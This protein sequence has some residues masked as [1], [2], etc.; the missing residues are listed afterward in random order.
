MQQLLKRQI[1]FWGAV[2]SLILL[3]IPFALIALAINLD[4]KGPVIFRYRA[5]VRARS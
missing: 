5:I 1:D 3:A 4:S 2:I